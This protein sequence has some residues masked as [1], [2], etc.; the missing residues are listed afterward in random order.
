MS[1]VA[2]PANDCAADH[3]VALAGAAMTRFGERD[4]RLF[5]LLVEAATGCLG[6]AGVDPTAVDHC[7]VTES[8]G[9]YDGGQ[10]LAGRLAGDLGLVPAYATCIEQTSA[11]GAAGVRAATR[12]VRAGACDCALVVGAEKMTHAPTE[13]VTDRVSAVTH[14]AAHRH[15]VTVPAFAGMTARRYLERFDAPR[16]SLARVAVKN[17]RHGL[18]NP[19]AHLRTAVDVETVLD[20]P[21]VADPLR[22]YDF[23][24]ISDGGAAVLVTSRTWARERG[25]A[26]ASLAGIAGA[27]D[28]HVVHERPDLTTV[29]AVETAGELAFERAGIASDDVDSLEVHDMFTILELLQLEALG[30]ADRGTAWRLTERGETARAGRL[31]V[32]TSGGLKSKGHPIA[33]S[34][35]AQLVECFEQLTGTAGERQVATDTAVACNV[36]GFGNCAIVSV[37]ESRR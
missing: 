19:K 30:F 9:S 4:E 5:G 11:A 32:N 7:Y 6:D 37:L 35:I 36:G 26:H 24:P 8:G 21:I 28:T 16:E 22:L 25:L 17:H 31:P 10:G 14:P 15:G 29:G 12:A 20:S 13:V 34:G 1:G 27:T 3:E 18:A 23:C 2:V 33:A